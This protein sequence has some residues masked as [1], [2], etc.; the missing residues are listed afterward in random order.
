MMNKM[1]SVAQVGWCLLAA[2]AGLVLAVWAA[3]AAD[4][5]EN[6][7][8]NPS[9]EN[10]RDQWHLDHSGR[11]VAQFTV[12]EKEAAAG[13]RSALISMGAVDGW[14]V[15]FG[16]TMEAPDLG[17][18]YTFAVL[19]KSV[20]APVALRL[21]IERRGD[22]YDRA[23]A[24]PRQTVTKDKWTEL[25]VTFKIDKPFP[26]GWFAYVSCNQPDAEFR[27]DMFRLVEGDYVPYE[28]AAREEIA[29]AAVALLDSVQPSP[30]PLSA[31]A[32]L[33]RKG[34]VQLPEDATD[35][36]F[37]GDAV[38]VNDRLALVLRRGAAGAELY[39]LGPAGP[40]LRAVL[41]PAGD[42]R[43]AE[44]QAVA[45]VAS[46]PSRAAVDAT[47]QSPG[48][49]KLTI[50][51][52]LAMGQTFVKTE[53]RA[54]AEGLSVEAPCRFLVLPD[55]FADDIVIDAAEIPMASAEIPSEN[56]LLHLLPDRQAIVMAV[57]ANRGEDA[58]INLSGQ[59]GGRLVRS[60]RMSYGKGGKIWVAVLDAPGVW[61]Q[62]GVSK[63]EAGK[64]LALDWTAP[65]PAQWR[66]DWRLRGRLTASWE[67]AVQLRS[68]EFLKYGWFGGA[69]T[70]PADRKRW[71]TVLG[72]F[73]YP[74]WLDQARRG[75]FQPLTRPER[76]EGP[77]VIYPI[78]RAKET[79]LREFTV[80]DI[81]RATLGVGPCE[82][83][84]D[85]EGQGATMKGRATCAT[86]DALGA[87]YSAK[88]QKQRR[89]DIE[90]LLDDVVIFVKHIRGRIEQYVAFGHATLAYLDQEKKAHPELS[91]VLADLEDSA[92]AIDAAFAGHKT[93]I[94]TP[95]Y[96]VDLTEK[97]RNTLLDYEGED[98]LKKCQAIT[99]AIVEVGGN[100]DELVGEC[101]NA[102]KVL[103]QRAAL[104]LAT[105]P[106]AAG[107]AREIRDRTQKALRNATS[108]ESPRH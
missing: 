30:A 29:A 16:Q 101:R 84:L 106:R 99:F 14:G 63:E 70:L 62:R 75:H 15:Q 57:A 65:F 21:E 86:R 37:R 33:G 55:F 92:R 35:T 53:P 81:V 19:A 27:L 64:I 76:F 23:A 66:V 22:P 39:G 56:F 13:Q 49:R 7:F 41:A 79:P 103:R 105:D 48:G 69:N 58:R 40:V 95:Q 47:F 91:G 98:A 43:A 90:R 88:Q 36:R 67:M 4:A 89:A 85:V 44:L 28:K 61:H 59:D 24:T 107:V 42:Q 54:G 8:G 87:I 20:K 72:S 71:T 94:K 2:A 102:V 80:V 93:A 1:R 18:T 11:T 83:I 108:Y 82:Y 45:V 50:R 26:Q 25:H 34:W 5:A 51:Y 96:V 97:F 77:A 52:E 46:D 3:P 104:A 60:S 6:L 10:G 32:I 68:G 74:C 78:Q 38:L 9:F 31:Q 12:D 17:K 73:L 100:Q